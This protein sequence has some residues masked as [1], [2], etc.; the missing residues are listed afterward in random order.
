MVLSHTRNKF[1]NA[2]THNSIEQTNNRSVKHSGNVSEHIA[3]LV[4]TAPPLKPHQA[5]TIAVLM[6]GSR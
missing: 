1:G 2:T 6:R 3:R 5:D 4:E